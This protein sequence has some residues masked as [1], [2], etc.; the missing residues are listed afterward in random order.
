MKVPFVSLSL[1]RQREIPSV[2][3][4]RKREI[5][6]NKKAWKDAF[7]KDIPTD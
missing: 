4:M 5:K 7:I 3:P 1:S 6:I 2:S